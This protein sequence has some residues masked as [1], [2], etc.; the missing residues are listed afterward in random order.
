MML[1]PSGFETLRHS[2]EISSLDESDRISD[3][4]EIRD[5]LNLF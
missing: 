5:L 3:T 2:A 4:G 1:G